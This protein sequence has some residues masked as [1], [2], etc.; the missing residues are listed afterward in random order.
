M[1][2]ITNFGIFVELENTVEGLVHISNMTDDYYRFEDRHM[3]MIGERTGR[4]FR[5]GDEVKIRVANVVIEESS[6]DFEIVDMVSS[7]RPA[8]RQTSKVIHAGRREGR[9]KM[10]S[11]QAKNVTANHVAE[12]RNALRKQNVQARLTVIH[13]GAA[14]KES[15]AISRSF[16]K[17]SQ[18][19]KKK[20]VKEIVRCEAMMHFR[21]HSS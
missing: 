12:A 2:S 19:A 6:V 3:M 11:V 16:T 1:S 14:K 17:A 7:P 9:K 20:K 5:I 8:R 21:H 13:A 18:K 10:M 15:Q 4:Q